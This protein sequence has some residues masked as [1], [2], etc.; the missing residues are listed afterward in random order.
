MKNLFLLDGTTGPV[1]SDLVACIEER[2]RK[3]CT[4]VNKFTTRPKRWYENLPGWRTDLIHRGKEEFKQAG[5]DFTYEYL[6][7]QYGFHRSHLDAALD[8]SDNVF[9]VVRS[10]DCIDRIKR[11]YSFMNVITVLLYAD[12]DSLMKRLRSQGFTENEI[13]SVIELNKT[14]LVGYEAEPGC[15]DEFI[16]S[17]CTV[18]N[19]RRHRDC[20][21]GKHKDKPRVKRNLV[22]VLM[23]FDK[24]DPRLE[25][26][27]A[28][29]Q[30]AVNKASGGEWHCASIRDLSAEPSIPE[31]VK[32]NIAACRLLIADLTQNRPSVLYELG[33]THGLNKECIIT[34][35]YGTKPFF[36]ILHERYIVYKNA[37]D[38]EGQLCD[39][40]RKRRNA[41]LI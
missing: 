19:M 13:S 17:F 35:E 36:F 2:L 26:Y 12:R 30:R 1:K 23:S 15:Y 5:Y 22:F 33:Y 7:N 39:E 27:Y 20:L 31:A 34:M 3:D 9:I 32:S 21:I 28:A 41:G 18:E 10:L 38:L 24:T 6:D 25:D 8:Q 14:T 40:L 4:L 29:M 11:S 16:I 37:G